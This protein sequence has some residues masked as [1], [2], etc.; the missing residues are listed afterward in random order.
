M[1]NRNHSVIE[2][3]NRFQNCRRGAGR[4]AAG[5][6]LH[7][8]RNGRAIDNCGKGAGEKGFCFKPVSKHDPEKW[9]P[10]FWTNELIRSLIL[11]KQAEA[12]VGRFCAI[13]A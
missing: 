2:D 8:D 1:A 10:V 4:P 13:A 3:S 7:H 12:T 5:P 9:K 6:R 11:L